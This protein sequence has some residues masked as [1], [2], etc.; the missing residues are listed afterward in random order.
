MAG[1]LA[2]GLASF[3]ALTSRSLNFFDE[4]APG[5]NTGALEPALSPGRARNQS[6]D[7]I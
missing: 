3:G 5:I 6:Q 2:H 1:F 4:R 7:G